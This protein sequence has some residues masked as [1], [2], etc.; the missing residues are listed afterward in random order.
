MS[1]KNV[2]GIDWSALGK[3]VHGVVTGDGDK[4]AEALTTADTEPPPASAC[5]TCA[6]GEKHKASDGACAATDG[7]YHCI[8]HNEEGSCVMAKRGGP[9]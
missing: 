1:E 8:A 6:K 7:E 3:L 2:L 4:I 5:E 9:R